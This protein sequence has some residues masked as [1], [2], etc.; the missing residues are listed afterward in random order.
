MKVEREN[1]EVGPKRDPGNNETTDSIIHQIVKNKY[2]D[3]YNP[4]A[5]SH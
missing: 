5:L 1:G 3:Q 2:K 4:E